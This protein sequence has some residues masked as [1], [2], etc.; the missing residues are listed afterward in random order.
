MSMPSL[1]HPSSSTPPSL[2]PPFAHSQTVLYASTKG[3]L[4][5]K[6]NGEG[7]YNL[8][9]EMESLLSANDIRC[10]KCV[11]RGRKKRMQVKMELKS[12]TKCSNLLDP[13]IVIYVK[14]RNGDLISTI[15]LSLLMKE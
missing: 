12:S 1:S 13:S 4:I 2:V 8:D 6:T 7:E 3:S 9:L 10:I 11:I 14:A 5:C 15:Q